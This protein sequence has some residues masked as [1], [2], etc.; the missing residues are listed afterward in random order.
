MPGTGGNGGGRCK[1]GAWHLSNRR[2]S[3]RAA[4][5]CAPW[6]PRDADA[7]HQ[8]CQDPEISRWTRVPTPYLYQHAVDFVSRQSP[9]SWASGTGALFAVVDATTEQLLASVGLADLSGDGDAKIG[10]WCAAPTR[11][12][13]VT[14][15]AVAALTRWGF[16]A[17]GLAR[18]EW[19]A[20][21][22]NLASRRVAEKAGFTVEGTLRRALLLGD[23]NRRDCW[24]GSLL[25]DDPAPR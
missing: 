7:V 20:A 24:V 10:Y 16:R 11:G 3:R 8:A 13:G 2:R 5:I 4:C 6:H 14:S 1:V 12:R 15:Q 17:L 25:P 21:V 18:I 9:Q 22:G 23:G 19:R